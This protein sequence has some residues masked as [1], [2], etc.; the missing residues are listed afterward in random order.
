M[1]FW[2]YILLI[3]GHISNGNNDED[4]KLYIALPEIYLGLCWI[5]YCQMLILTWKS[6]AGWARWLMPVI[7]ALWEADTGGSP[8]DRSSRPAWPTWRNPVSTKKYKIGWAW[9]CM[10]VIPAAQEAE[11]GEWPEPR[12]RRWRWAEISHCTTAWATRAK[13]HLKKKK[14]KRKKVRCHAVLLWVL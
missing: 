9:W 11:A 8:E 10:P 7:P 5:C 1:T 4:Y 14:K 6:N 2:V 3:A 13:L 12:R